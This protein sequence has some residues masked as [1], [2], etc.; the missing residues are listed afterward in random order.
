MKW[1][2]PQA[3]PHGRH[4]IVFEWSPDASGPPVGRGGV[5]TLSVN[6]QRV[7]ERRMERSVPFCLQWDEPFD[8][9]QDTGTL[10]NLTIDLGA[11]TL[12]PATARN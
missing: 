3:L 4:S 12:P 10:Q 8:V 2:G 1:E 9:G 7:A 11:S 6:G 5:G